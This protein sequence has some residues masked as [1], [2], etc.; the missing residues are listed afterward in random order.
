MA[1]G[2]ETN[3]NSVSNSLSHSQGFKTP[4]PM[5]LKVPTK[6]M[7]IIDQLK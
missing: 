7:N 5:S 4:E 1:E 2:N 3:Q 6:E